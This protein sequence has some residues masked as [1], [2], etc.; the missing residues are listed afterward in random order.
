M[1]EVWARSV[2]CVARGKPF[3]LF[4]PW[5]HLRQIPGFSATSPGF[6]FLHPLSPCTHVRFGCQ[7]GFCARRGYYTY[8]SLLLHRAPRYDPAAQ[9]QSSP[10][11]AVQPPSSSS[12]QL[13]ARVAAFV[14]GDY[15]DRSLRCS[16]RLDATT[17]RCCCF[18][19]FCQVTCRRK[20]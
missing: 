5:V 18:S 8:I 1:P 11:A 3:K 15:F 6:G 9:Q 14:V 20:V 16:T 12:L 7:P 2:Q 4:W 17:S 19:C 10:L 13:Y